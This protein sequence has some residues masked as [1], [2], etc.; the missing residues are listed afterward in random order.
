LGT[1]VLS[2]MT[3]MVLVNTIYLKAPWA[4]AFSKSSTAPASFTRSDG[5]TVQVD[6]MHQQNSMTYA[7]ATGWKAVVMPYVGGELEMALIVPDAGKLADSITDLGPTLTA[8]AAART[9]MV[10]LAMPKFDFGTKTELSKALGQLGMPTAFT[11]SADFG[12]MTKT[13]PLFISAVVH[14]AN[15]TVDEEGT[16][17]AAATAAV[18]SATAMPAQPIA[19]TIDRPFVMAIRDAKTGAVLFLGTINDPTDHAGAAN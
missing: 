12:A 1:G 17:A 16:V 19:L 11:D 7:E 15:I 8:L 9:T 14:Q 3:R 4:S 6:M 2:A 5:S 18:M 13:E 10:Q